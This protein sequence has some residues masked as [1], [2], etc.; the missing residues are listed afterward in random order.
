MLYEHLDENKLTKLKDKHLLKEIG[1]PI[2][3]AKTCFFI[4]NTTFI[5][6]NN[7]ILD[8]GILAQLSSEIFFY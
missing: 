3:I 5:N 4:N 2:D 8:G 7:I 1:N 6:G